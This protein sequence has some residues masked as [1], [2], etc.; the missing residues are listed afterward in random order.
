MQVCPRWLVD[1]V[2]VVKLWEVVRM[3][4][5]KVFGWAARQGQNVEHRLSDR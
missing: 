5:S 4:T 2:G 3:L 1:E